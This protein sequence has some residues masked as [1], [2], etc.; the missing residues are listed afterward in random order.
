MKAMI[1]IDLDMPAFRGPKTG[2]EVARMLRE[3][4]DTLA[5]RED[6][7]FQSELLMVDQSG[8]ASGLFWTEEPR[9]KWVKKP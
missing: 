2:A 5:D 4:A 7:L 6:H 1:E 9:L 8:R 3:L